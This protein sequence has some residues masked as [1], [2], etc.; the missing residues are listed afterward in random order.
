MKK[1]SFRLQ[2]FLE[3]IEKRLEQ[4]KI[5][6]LNLKRELVRK[7]LEIFDKNNHIKKF[8]GDFLINMKKSNLKPNDIKVWCNCIDFETF[9]LKT[10]ET[11]KFGIEKKLEVI[12]KE[13]ME[14]D[15]SLKTVT[16]LKDRKLFNYNLENLKFEQ[17]EMDE[18]G[19]R[20]FAINKNQDR[21]TIK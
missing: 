6:L 1:F 17:Y 15:R 4:K 16:K 19:S 20:N 7:E 21:G 12:K 8:E 9:K 10:L 5:E 11:E 3:I 2:K 18:I 14:I 13:Y